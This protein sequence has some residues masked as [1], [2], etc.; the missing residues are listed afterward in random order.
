MPTPLQSALTAARAAG[1][2]LH[3]KFL[4]PR[5]IT[6][7]G[8]RDIVTDA[9]FA[10]QK[11][12]LEILAKDFPDHAVL[13]EEGRRDAQ[14]DLAAPVP[15]WVIDPLDGTANYSRQFPAFSVAIGLVH[16]GEILLGVIHDPMQ[17]ET[18]F[19]EK[20]QG[21]FIQ[22]GGDPPQPMQ[23]SRVADLGDVFVGVDWA[24]DPG[25]R[26]RVL[27]ALVR[28]GAEARTIRAIGSAALGMAYVAAGR[29]D[30]YYHLALQPWDVAAGAI[31]VTEAGG[32]L[33]APDGSEW[34]LGN[35]QLVASNGALHPL[36][37]KTLA[38][39]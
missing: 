31:I 32:Q 34:R 28:V 2:I 33:S 36:M 21:A 27:E 37:V 20:G 38:L 23:V 18:F 39:A 15:T 10:A 8:W 9:D 11:A 4:H 25:T 12:I 29:L 17:D 14:A 19:A 16:Q 35:M 24:R 3:D 13:S 7:K 22:Y 26:Q 30:G 6:S 1:Q 5:E